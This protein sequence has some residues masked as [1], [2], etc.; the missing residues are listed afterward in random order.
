[1]LSLSCTHYISIFSCQLIGQSHRT[2]SAALNLAIY[3]LR[4]YDDPDGPGEFATKSNRAATVWVRLTIYT[5]S[6]NLIMRVFQRLVIPYI[7]FGVFVA[8]GVNVR[9]PQTEVLVSDF[10]SQDCPQASG[11]SQQGTNLLLLLFTLEFAVS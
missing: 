8:I 10:N 11:P 4:T 3:I 9:F 5:T 1:M 7:A 2:C 6:S